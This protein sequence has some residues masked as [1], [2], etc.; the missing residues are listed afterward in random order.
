MHKNLE[1]ATDLKE[2]CVKFQYLPYWNI[3]IMEDL[4]PRMTSTGSRHIRRVP[5][6]ARPPVPKLVD[7]SYDG[8]QNTS[9]LKM[10]RATRSTGIRKRGRGFKKRKREGDERRVLVL[11]DAAAQE[12]RQYSVPSGEHW[13]L[14]RDHAMFRGRVRFRS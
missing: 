13:T 1:R 3:S 7:S 4:K 9:L 6:V 2:S 14:G 10:T 5:V 12:Q 8:G 11:G